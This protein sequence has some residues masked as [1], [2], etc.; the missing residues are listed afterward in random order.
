[1]KPNNFRQQMTGTWI[2]QST[3]Y[4][5]LNKN[6]TSCN[7]V[8]KI[9][10]LYLKNNLTYLKSLSKNNQV[11]FLQKNM[12]LYHIQLSNKQ[13]KDED[14]YLTL[15]IDPCNKAYLLK[16]DNSFKLINKFFIKE[17]TDSSLCLLGYVNSY[18]V[19]QRIYFLNQ[20]VK[21]I[22][23]IIKKNQNYIGTSFTS[24]IRIS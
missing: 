12:D 16:F 7:F 10:W 20:N 2:T 4:S 22:K 24:E 14:Y 11:N 21:L 6:E 17:I 5:L 1:M 18:E 19:L 23:V 8:N 3:Y 13:N 9:E 15:Q